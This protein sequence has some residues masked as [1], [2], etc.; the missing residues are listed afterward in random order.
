MSDPN[1]VCR[2]CGERRG[3]HLPPGETHPREARGEGRYEE[4]SAGHIQGGGAWLDD[5]WVAPTYR[6]VPAQVV[7]NDAPAGEPLRPLANDTNE[8]NG[9][10]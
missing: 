2:I 5:T 9:D 7:V 1:E 8:R 4:V 10:E 3:N 6:F